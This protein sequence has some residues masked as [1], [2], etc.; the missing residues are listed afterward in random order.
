MLHETGDLKGEDW[1]LDSAGVEEWL[2]LLKSHKL[3][4][5]VF[6]G[7]GKGTLEVQPFLDEDADP[8]DIPTGPGTVVVLRADILLHT[9]R[10]IWTSYVMSSF[11]LETSHRWT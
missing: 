10:S 2:R 6:L 11:F 1:E 8:F 7:P 9:H 3:M 4:C 5:L